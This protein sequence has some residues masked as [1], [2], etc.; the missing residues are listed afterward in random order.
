MLKILGSD[1]HLD[2]GPVNENGRRTNARYVHQFEAKGRVGA[3]AAK[4]QDWDTILA[5]HD[6]RGPFLPRS[7]DQS[8]LNSRLAP[9]SDFR[10]GASRSLDTDQGNLNSSTS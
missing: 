2:Q 6:L 1:L 3:E 9:Y 5:C 8:R 7:L 10:F 4:H